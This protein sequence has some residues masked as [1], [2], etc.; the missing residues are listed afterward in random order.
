MKG[1][2]NLQLTQF[3]PQKS[4]IAREGR[5]HAHTLVLKLKVVTHPAS[6]ILFDDLFLL[7]YRSSETTDYDVAVLGGNRRTS[8]PEVTHMLVSSS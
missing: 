6:Q 8:S 4:I 1:V 3:E 2:K 7:T 5:N